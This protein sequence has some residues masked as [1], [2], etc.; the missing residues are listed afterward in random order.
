MDAISHIYR[1]RRNYARHAALFAFY[2]MG[3]AI[4]LPAEAY[5]RETMRMTL[6]NT[7]DLILVGFIWAAFFIAHS[8]TQWASEREYRALLGA[9]EQASEK[10]KRAHM[11]LTDDG[12]LEEIDP[13]AVQ[14]E[15]RRLRLK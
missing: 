15:A 11:H 13:L 6:P 5:W 1:K 3:M 2:I 9:G 12:E 10:A 4:F 7:G 14:P 8:A